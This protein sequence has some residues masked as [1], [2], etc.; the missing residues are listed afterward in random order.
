PPPS[1]DGRMSRLKEFL[2]TFFMPE[3]CYDQFFLYF[4]F[5]HGERH[6]Q[7]I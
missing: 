1:A 5:M 6:G 4:N 3:R 7:Y 2:L